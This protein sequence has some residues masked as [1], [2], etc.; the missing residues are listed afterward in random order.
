MKNSIS[1][2]EKKERR[3]RLHFREKSMPKLTSIKKLMLQNKKRKMQIKQL[4]NKI[5]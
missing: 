5:R 1:Q 4:K 2:K 3:R